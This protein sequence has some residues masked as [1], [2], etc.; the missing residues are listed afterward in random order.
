[1]WRGCGVIDLKREQ[2]VFRVRTEVDPME[3][4]TGEKAADHITP[5]LDPVS[6]AYLQDRHVQLPHPRSLLLLV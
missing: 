2:R 4:D 1:M 6:D 3:F 5:R